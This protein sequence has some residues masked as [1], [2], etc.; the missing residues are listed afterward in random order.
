MPLDFEFKK[1]PIS[2]SKFKIQIS[3]FKIQNPNF[4]FSKFP[5][6]LLHTPRLI[7]VDPWLT[8]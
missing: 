2:K 8:R 6:C 5:S 7:H 1:I 4:K 3:K